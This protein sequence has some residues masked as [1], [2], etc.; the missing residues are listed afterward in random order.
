MNEPK[1]NSIHRIDLPRIVLVGQDVIKQLGYICKEFGYKKSLIVTGKTTYK[2]AG[3][4]TEHLLTEQGIQTSHIIV[5][6]ATRETIDAVKKEVSASEADVVFGIG[7]GRN[8]DIAK[9][10]A[11]ETKRFFISVPTVASHDGIASSLASIKGSGRPYTVSAAS[12]IA[13]VMDS[14]I[15]QESPYRFTAAGCGD[16]I[17]KT[18]E[19]RDWRLAHRENNDYYGGYASSLSLMSS[20]HVMEKAHIIREKTQE[21]IRT[22]LEALVSCGVAMSIAGSSRPTSGSSHLFS[23][24]LDQIAKKPAL[25]GEQCGVGS[26]IMA[27]LHGLNWEAIRSS[28][29]T[30]GAPINAEELGVSDKNIIMA[31]KLAKTIR[32]ERYTILNKIELDEKTAI[33]IAEFTGVI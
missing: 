27:K 21:G 9:V 28:L 33:Q 29:K 24:A 23:H 13:V 32:P 20:Q 25:H 30:I 31:L 15:I 5:S 4:T 12:P 11:Y 14:K 17:C 6:E 2:V 26:I 22:L 3:E 8:I 1:T 10:S 7:G 18:V 19:V 16:M